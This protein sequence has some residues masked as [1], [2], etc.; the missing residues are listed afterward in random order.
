MAY[1]SHVEKL[2]GDKKK[3]FT[4]RQSSIGLVQNIKWKTKQDFENERLFD[5]HKDFENDDNGCS[6]TNSS[7]LIIDFGISLQ[8]YY[9]WPQVKTLTHTEWFVFSSQ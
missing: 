5:E 2:R 7:R 4:N 8:I 3:F 6:D 9:K 1:I